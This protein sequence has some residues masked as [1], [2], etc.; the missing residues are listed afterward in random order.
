MTA[1]NTAA[2]P[3]AAPFHGSWGLLTYCV[4][5]LVVTHLFV[6]IYE[7]PTLRT[8]FGVDYL[9]YCKQVPRW[10]PRRRAA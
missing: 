6:V 8:T 7:E 4:A 9:N 3:G 10:F 2:P 1:S 5:F